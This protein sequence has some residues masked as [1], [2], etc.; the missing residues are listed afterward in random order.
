MCEENKKEQEQEEEIVI[1]KSLFE[2]TVEMTFEEY[3][4]LNNCN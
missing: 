2:K 4:K 3:I 1:D